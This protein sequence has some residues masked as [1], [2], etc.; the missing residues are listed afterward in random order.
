MPG[1]RVRPGTF[2]V[3]QPYDRTTSTPAT[4]DN[5]SNTAVSATEAPLTPAD[6]LAPTLSRSCKK[7]KLSRHADHATNPAEQELVSWIRSQL[8]TLLDHT[9][10]QSLV[11]GMP[12]D[13]FYGTCVDAPV[14]E[15]FPLDLVKLQPMLRMLRTGFASAAIGS[16]ADGDMEQAVFDEILLEETRAGTNGSQQQV[17]DMGDI[18]ETLVMNEH[19]EPS[20][21]SFPTE[22]QPRY[23][24]P[25]RSGFIMSD[26]DRIDGLKS[27]A[28][29]RG[30]FDIIVMDPPW[31]NASV[32][33]M[34]HY[35]TLDLYDLFKIPI[36]DL[37]RTNTNPEQDDICDNR[38]D[39]NAD[40]KTSQDAIVAVWITNRAKVKKVVIEKLFPAWGLELVAHWYWLK[41]TTHG[42]PVLS[43]ENT[44]RRA[45][46]GVL[47]GRRR[48]AQSKKQDP[49]TSMGPTITRRLLVSVPS[50]HS[51]KPSLMH[52]LEQEFFS[53]STISCDPSAFSGTKE[54]GASTP[55][56]ITD[57]HTLGRLELFARNLEEGVLSWGNEPIRYQYCGR[58]SE[59]T[60]IV[61]DGYWVLSSQAPP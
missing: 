43:L 4:L 12:V 55:E 61:Q 1:W 57:V 39:S 21:I 2:R 23:L 36:P 35:G 60:G 34:S 45:Y 50:Q 26:L 20:I 19:P 27:I 15:D 37:L 6:S 9:F 49:S 31:Q 10:A 33:R 51:R 8:Q 58:G 3:A 11:D 5:P 47:I 44:H 40:D 25:P 7:R 41:M 53:K 52:L 13:Y 14:S 48:T 46:E 24:I 30:G 38:N 56:S 28:H 29:Q 42:E 16:V 18:Y 59:S 22:G 32:D 17:V 54:A